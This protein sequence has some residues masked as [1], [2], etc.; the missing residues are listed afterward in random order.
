MI[1]SNLCAVLGLSFTVFVS[2]CAFSIAGQPDATADSN[3][4]PTPA[5]A[6]TNV[7]GASSVSDSVTADAGA[8]V[9]DSASDEVIVPSLVNGT[10]GAAAIIAAATVVTA[11]SQIADGTGG[12]AAAV[13]TIT[14]TELGNAVAAAETSTG[15]TTSVTTTAATTS[16]TLI[17]GTGGS[18]ATSATTAAVTATGGAAPIATSTT[19]SAA[20]GGA[21]SAT[22][23][24]V[25]VATGG[26]PAATTT[27]PTMVDMA[28]MKGSAPAIAVSD[29]TKG[30]CTLKLSGEYLLAGHATKAG[31]RGQLG[32]MY[33]IGYESSLT[34]TKNDDGYFSLTFKASDLIST[35][36]DFTYGAVTAIGS[37]SF[38]TYA[39]YGLAEKLNEMTSVGR[40]WVTCNWYDAATKTV[41]NLGG[42]E[43][44]G[45]KATVTS[46]GQKCS[47]TGNGNMATYNQ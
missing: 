10:G 30:T 31:L 2:G 18:S 21:T 9:V 26:T 46:D 45:L 1:K 4:A 12:A 41:L 44:C 3:A 39:N 38:F 36:A 33:T 11:S 19:P 22:T 23:T 27:V 24:A 20:T 35:G 14:V 16:V 42:K 28:T 37:E 34:L 29:D 6:A 7:A 5:P 47:F 8:A 13:E 43:S 25:P 17:T 32:P 40:S 15:G